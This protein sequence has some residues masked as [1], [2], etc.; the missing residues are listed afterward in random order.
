MVRLTF[1]CYGLLLLSLIGAH[2]ILQ[3]MDKE[4]RNEK[5]LQCIP[6]GKGPEQPDSYK[7]RYP[8]ES[9]VFELFAEMRAILGTEAG[10]KEVTAIWQKH[11]WGNW[12]AMLPD[13]QKKVGELKSKTTDADACQARQENI[14]NGDPTK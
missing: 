5:Y 2:P 14:K 3:A 8:I 13:A 1:L 9:E 12:E 11:G 10:A 7:L 4:I 6:L